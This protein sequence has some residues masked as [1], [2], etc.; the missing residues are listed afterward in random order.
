MDGYLSGVDY[1]IAFC[2]KQALLSIIHVSTDITQNNEQ[3]QH[4]SQIISPG[5]SPL[6]NIS[7]IDFLNDDFAFKVQ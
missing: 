6:I 2:Y 5:S 7:D 4:P 3:Q 1:A